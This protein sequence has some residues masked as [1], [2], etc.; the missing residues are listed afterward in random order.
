M[1]TSR[2]AREHKDN[3]FTAYVHATIE[4]ACTIVF[5]GQS[6][7]R[8]WANTRLISQSS[9]RHSVEQ[10][11]HVPITLEMLLHPKLPAACPAE[12]S[13]GNSKRQM[14]SWI[15]SLESVFGCVASYH[16]AFAAS[17]H[18]ACRAIR[19]KHGRYADTLEHGLPSNLHPKRL[20]ALLH[21]ALVDRSLSMALRKLVD[22]LLSDDLV[23]GPLG[24]TRPG[25]E[26][27]S[28]ILEQ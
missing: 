3:R 11:M 14:R 5:D 4:S 7:C 28:E 1:N 26:A 18:D 21:Q 27:V 20:L 12:R 17:E 25:R 9:F 16:H 24:G 6:V 8:T 19:S 15:S 22:H 23:L 10:K 13:T 2:G